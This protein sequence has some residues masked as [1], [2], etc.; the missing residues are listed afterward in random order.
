MRLDS[1][2]QPHLHVGDYAA[3]VFNAEVSKDA[4]PRLRAGGPWVPKAARSRSQPDHPGGLPRGHEAV[5]EGKLAG[6]QVPADEQLVAGRGGTDLGPG[7]PPLPLGAACMMRDPRYACMMLCG[8]R[9]LSPCASASP[10]C[11]E[12][13]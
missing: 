5:M 13:S 8:K 1:A 9:R 6:A 7:V 3:G 11:S 10:G 4:H 12:V 2:M